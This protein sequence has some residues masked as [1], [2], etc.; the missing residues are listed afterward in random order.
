VL[1]NDLRVRDEFLTRKGPHAVIDENTGQ[2]KLEENVFDRKPITIP[3]HDWEKAAR[4]Y[5]NEKFDD[6]E[7]LNYNQEIHRQE[8]D[9]IA[10]KL[11]HLLFNPSQA[12][13][14]ENQLLLINENR[15]KELNNRNNPT[16]PSDIGFRIAFSEVHNLSTHA[17]LKHHSMYGYNRCEVEQEDMFTHAD[18]VG[19]YQGPDVGPDTYIYR[20]SC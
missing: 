2:M 1:V 19:G 18:R 9:L 12:Y 17:R 16:N 20:P 11:N 6:I 5:P 13:N 7:F 8:S 15:L 14:H 4:E 3:G 10:E